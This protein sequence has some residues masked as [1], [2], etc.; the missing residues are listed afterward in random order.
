MQKNILTEVISNL[1]SN[2]EGHCCLRQK[3]GW[4][5]FLRNGELPFEPRDLHR[6]LREVIDEDGNRPRGRKLFRLDKRYEFT[7]KEDKNPGRPEEALERFIIVSNGQGFSNQIPI[8]RGK[9]SIDI[10]IMEG[11]S[12]FTFVE[13]KPW[14]SSNSPMYAIVERLKNLVEYRIIHEK[15]I[16]EID[17]F[18]E[19]SLLILAP[20]QYYQSYGLIDEQGEIRKKEMSILK[21][22]LDGM[23]SEFETDISFMSLQLK[24][25]DF[26]DACWALYDRGRR[27]GR[28]KVEVTKGDVIHAL[29]RD[30]W[31]L[32]VASDMA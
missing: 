18:Y 32:L 28:G 10:G 14:R 26:L 5:E 30:M 23:S 7:A 19:V 1:N 12:K 29:K 9:E 16:Q 17:P 31:K 3:R 20:S 6:T 8:G 11:A 4:L 25:E 2:I 21:S 22:A 15:K 24:W 27:E 13:L